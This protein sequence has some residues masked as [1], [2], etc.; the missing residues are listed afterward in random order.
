MQES[1]MSRDVILLFTDECGSY[2]KDKSSSFVKAHPFYVRANLMINLDDY[3]LVEKDYYNCKKKIGIDIR[4]EIKWSHYGNAI[5]NINVPF[6]PEITSKELELFYKEAIEALI[7]RKSAKVFYTITYNPKVKRIDEV[8]LIKMH[9]Q[10]AFQRVQKEAELIPATAF[11]IAD[12]LNAKNKPLKKAMFDLTADGDLYTKY[13]CVNKGL[14]IDYSDQ[15]C[16]LQLADICAGIFTAYLKYTISDEK[17]MNKYRFAHDMF[18][19]YLYS[20]IRADNTRGEW[21][22]VYGYGIRN[23]PNECGEDMARKV[24]RIVQ[25]LRHNELMD[26]IINLDANE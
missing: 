18:E 5:K 23:V 3:L 11:V 19:Q 1:T 25:G 13:E 20:L 22:K 10:N 4:S 15:C 17:E 6:P 8:K 2:Q 21:D 14:F 26:Y 7:K 16:G 12:D 24:S 9:L